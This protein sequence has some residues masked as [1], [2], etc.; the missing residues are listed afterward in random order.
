VFHLG[1]P[2]TCGIVHSTTSEGSKALKQ[3]GG[4]RKRGRWWEF[5]LDLPRD[6]DGKRRQLWRGH[7]RTH[8]EAVTAR[9][10]ALA[11]AKEGVNVASTRVTLAAYL[12]E[13]WLPAITSRVRPSTYA[14]YEG[15][16]RVHIT[17]DIGTRRLQD[18]RGPDFNAFYGRLFV[19]ALSAY[20]VRHVHAVLHRALKDAVRWQLVARN[21]AA[22]ANPPSPDTEARE[23]KT[24]SPGEVAR[25]LEAVDELGRPRVAMVTTRSR[26][27]TEYVRPVT[28]PPDPMQVALWYT[29]ALTGMR[30][31]EVAGLRWT[32]ID[33]EARTVSIQRARVMV[34]GAVEV[35]Q[36][37][38]KHGRRVVALVPSVTAVLR[39]WQREQEAEREETGDAW[40]DRDGYVFT[41]AVRFSEPIRYG[42]AIRPDWVSRSFR[43]LIARLGLPPIRLHDL[44]HTW[45]TLALRAGE[46]PKVVSD[47]LGHANISITMDTY[48]HV[49]IGLEKHAA[50]RV[51]ALIDERRKDA[52]R[53]ERGQTGEDGTAGR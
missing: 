33:L 48:S 47:H 31:G 17:P 44:R 28:L 16:I 10:K 8:A 14:L 11:A 25:F 18:L 24:W 29:I 52:R 41:H 42:T 39:T 43:A 30:R 32:D 49:T 38:T 21:A 7:F 36:P 40:E 35:S 26:S 5:R 53:T 13:T 3:R 1:L 6:P 45:A 15:L 12:A 23:M 19:K 20:S 27:G 22:D 9:A 50:H 37:K 4:V 51:A 46:S 2:V 34:A